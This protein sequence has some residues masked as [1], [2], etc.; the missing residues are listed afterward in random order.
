MKNQEQHASD[1]NY[2]CLFKKAYE[3]VKAG[4]SENLGVSYRYF[5]SKGRNQSINCIHFV[6]RCN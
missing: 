2:G 4:V 3:N 5:H 6:Y 1:E